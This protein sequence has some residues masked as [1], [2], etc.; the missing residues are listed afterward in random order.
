M[1]ALPVTEVWVRR[2][3]CPLHWLTLTLLL[4]TL[5]VGFPVYRMELIIALPF[6]A[7]PVNPQGDQP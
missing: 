2:Q 4:T 5:N 3:Q 7:K 6:K 1:G